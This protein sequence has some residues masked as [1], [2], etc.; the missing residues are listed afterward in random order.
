M[1]DTGVQYHCRSD[2][3]YMCSPSDLTG[4][5]GQ[6]QTGNAANATVSSTQSGINTDC[7]GSTE[8]IWKLNELSFS[9]FALLIAYLCKEQA[10]ALGATSHKL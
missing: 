3:I 6:G 10:V 2:I 7:G 5:M 4:D 9:N 8:N 1:L